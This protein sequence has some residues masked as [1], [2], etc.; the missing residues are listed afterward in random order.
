[1]NTAGFELTDLVNLR[2]AQP[3]HHV[4]ARQQSRSIRTDARTG[5]FVV[6]VADTGSN[7]STCFDDHI[8]AEPHQLFNRFRSRGDAILSRLGFTGYD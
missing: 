2:L 6:C 5:S 8:R 4:G 3:E 7:A 1:M